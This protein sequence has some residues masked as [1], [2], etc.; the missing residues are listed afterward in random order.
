MLR[1]FIHVGE[2]DPDA[3]VV[4][5]DGAAAIEVDVLVA[6]DAPMV[7]DHV[8][9]VAGVVDAEVL[10]G[11]GEGVGGHAAGRL[12]V[13]VVVVVLGDVDVVGVAEVEAGVPPERAGG[14]DERMVLASPWTVSLCEGVLVPMPTKPLTYISREL[15]VGR[16]GWGTPME[17]PPGRR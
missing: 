5:D 11:G 4:A 9:G 15:A 3:A 2:L 6:L 16:G 14:A 13:E 8:G 12:E 17:T 7:E 10:G 1:S